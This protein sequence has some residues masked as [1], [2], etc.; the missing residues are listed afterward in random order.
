MQFLNGTA[1]GIYSYHWAIV[2]GAS[3]NR[4]ILL[5]MMFLKSPD[6]LTHPVLG[7]TFD[8]GTVRYATYVIFHWHIILINY[9]NL[10]CIFFPLTPTALTSY[11]L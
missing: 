4:A 2:E 7:I 6:S 1:L 9:V 8:W 3:V 10:I 5:F 11:S